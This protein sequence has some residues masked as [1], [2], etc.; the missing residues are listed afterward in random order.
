MSR[1]PC[2]LGYQEIEMIFMDPIR[3]TCESCKGLRF[4]SSILEVY[5]KRKNIHQILQ[6]TVNQAMD[7]FKAHPSIFQPLSLLKKVGLEYLKL[8]QSLSTLSGGEAQRMKLAREL[9]DSNIK[10]AF[11]IF[12]EPSTGLHIQEIDL[13][14]KVLDK[15][16]D[17][18]ATVLLIEHNLQM[19]SNCDYI[20][21]LGPKAGDEGGHVVGHGPLN[22]FITKNK[23]ATAQSLRY[24]LNKKP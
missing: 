23:G 19:I 17:Q 1:M 4:Q 20:I 8:G 6:M 11:Y 12:D 5:F 18:G 14:L 15:L 3:L 2:G 13:L 21:D 7:F 22:D 16:I 9:A 10:G 24:Y